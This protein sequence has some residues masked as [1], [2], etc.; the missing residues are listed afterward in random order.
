M[1][2]VKLNPLSE[3]SHTFPTMRVHHEIRRLLPLARI[4]D[5]SL[6][7][8]TLSLRHGDPRAFAEA[9]ARGLA[10]ECVKIADMER[11]GHPQVDVKAH[12][13]MKPEHFTELG[14]IMTELLSIHV[15]GHIWIEKL[16]ILCYV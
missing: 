1:S 7:S 12:C 5:L 10:A 14:A 11:L 2:P 4:S 13:D 6:S 16:S 3:D 8:E 15:H 9:A